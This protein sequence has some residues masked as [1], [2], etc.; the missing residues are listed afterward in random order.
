MFMRTGIA[1]GVPRIELARAREFVAKTA[2]PLAKNARE[3]SSQARALGRAILSR[4]D[5]EP[6]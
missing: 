5:R 6:V 2:L 4:I 1:S 3:P